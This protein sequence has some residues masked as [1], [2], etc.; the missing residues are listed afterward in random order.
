M[1]LLK[2]K[3]MKIQIK[4]FESSEDTYIAEEMFNR[5]ISQRYINVKNITV[6]INPKTGFTQYYVEYSDLR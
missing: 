1:R 2:I 5:F 6:L 3:K 4:S